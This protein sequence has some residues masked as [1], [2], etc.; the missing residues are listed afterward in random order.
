MLAV[1]QARLNSQ[2][3]PGKALRMLG[4][5][6]ILERTINRL[7]Q[8]KKITTVVVATSTEKTDAPIAEHAQEIGTKIYRGEL[9]DVGNR[10][11]NA[12]KSMG[13]GSFVRISGDSPF[14]DWRLVDQAIDLHNIS[15]ADLVSNIF[16]RTYPKGQSVEIIKTAS[17]AKLCKSERTNEE[18]EHVTPYFYKNY[19]KFCIINFTSGHNHSRSNHCIDDQTD[20]ETAQKVVRDLPGDD[21]SWQELELLFSKHRKKLEG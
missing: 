18:K 2:R 7:K 1:I 19:N 12:A 11:L 8:S 10:L 3:L 14:I 20:F 6:N 21:L 9:E 4:K 15:E 16:P 13:S 17:L 5:K